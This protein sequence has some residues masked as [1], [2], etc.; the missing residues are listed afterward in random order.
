MQMLFFNDPGEDTIKDAVTWI[1]I[2]VSN[3]EYQCSSTEQ[4]LTWYVYKGKTYSACSMV[5]DGKTKIV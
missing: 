1:K 5:W 2:L 4:P 3:A